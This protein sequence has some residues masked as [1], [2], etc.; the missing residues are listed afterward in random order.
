[1]AIPSNLNHYTIIE[2]L[3]QG[4]MGE[5][6]VAQDTKLH[7]KVAL[8]VL[9]GLTSGDPER[10]ARFER[11]ARAVAALN[12]PSIVTIHSVE[13]AN[14]LPFLT[15]ELV[16]GK[17]LTSL[18]TDSGL[19]L[20]TLLRIGIGI[21]DA[22]AAA[23]QRGITH[24][25]LKPAN[26][27]VTDE[28]RVKVLDFG[29]AKLQEHDSHLDSDGVTLL[30]AK[31]LTGEGRIIGTVAYMSPEQAEGKTVDQR[32]DIFSLGVLLHEMATGQRPF[33][34]ETNVSVMSAILRDTPSSITDINPKLPVGLARIIKRALTKD[35]SRRYQTATDL[36]NDLEELKQEIDSAA[37]M[38][39]ASARSAAP[40]RAIST[41]ALLVGLVALLAIGGIGAALWW[42]GG[43]GV[44]PAA[45]FEVDRFARLTN[46]G[47]AQIAAMSPDGRYV[48]HIKSESGKSALWIRQTATSSDVQIVPPDEVRYDGL[49]FSPDG[50]FVYY[51]FYGRLGGVASLYRIPVLGGSGQ[52]LVEDVDSRISFSPD[53]TR[54][55]FLRGSPSEGRNYLMIANADGSGARSLSSAT[56]S[57][58]FL[59][60]APA[61][62]PDGHTILAGV[63]ALKEGPH[64]A[65]LAVTVESGAAQVVGG[66]W[67]FSHDVEWMPDGRSFVLAAVDFSG[68][69]PQLWQVMYPS[70]ERR[71]IT[72]DLNSYSGVSVSRDGS[73]IATVQVENSSSIWVVDV[74]DP[75]KPSQLTTG[76]NRDDGTVGL[77]WTADGRIV[78]SSSASGRLEIWIMDGD[79]KNPRPLTNE[80]TPPLFASASPD[81]RFIVFQSPQSTG[82]F[83]KRIATDG[84]NVENLTRGG[85]EFV[86][87]VSPDSKWVYYN[88]PL[89]GSPRAFKVPMDGG[90][91][92]ALSDGYLRPTAVSPDGTL[93]LGIGWDSKLRRA[94]YATLPTSGGTP[95]LLPLTATGIASFAPDGKGIVYPAFRDGV[96]NLHLSTK[97][98]KDR[99]ITQ[100]TSD[101]IAQFAWSRDGKRVAIA[102]G[103]GS[104]DVVVLTRKQETT[105]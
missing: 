23:H 8:K 18:L 31:D 65:V 27:M 52:K 67:G 13:E 46:G 97:D 94:V 68:Q 42:W 41:S 105:R 22:M 28:G 17:P 86:P 29:L 35:P 32:S 38:S 75:A 56:A 36:R 83:L 4:G 61:W 95:T 47:T 77:S 21:S 66:R 26:V 25:D 12:H 96:S 78:F 39:I 10:R 76:R 44:Q 49:T 81:G 1:M 55:A 45:T 53:G 2:P 50:N 60:N 34:G 69:T 14:G 80:S 104:S 89:S 59:L 3:G 64:H 70:G 102:R 62:S 103:S 98:G 90:E 100:F 7:R 74:A 99:P 48:V 33:K 73:S 82:M 91:P 5:V 16:E 93:L 6:F 11:E 58:Q 57:E 15:M 37:T 24:R 71:R 84:T 43:P 79:G 51:V 20:D 54:F 30:P 40:R 101:N 92:I 88:S 19:P 9:S 87:L 85:S 72:N 63:Q